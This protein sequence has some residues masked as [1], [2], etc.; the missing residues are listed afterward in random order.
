M[1]LIYFFWMLKIGYFSFY[2]SSDIEGE[3]LNLLVVVG[4][5]LWV[6]LASGYESS[7]RLSEG[8]GVES[9]IVNFMVMRGGG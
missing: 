7:R 3:Y 9:I 5:G 1:Y 2:N 6:F 4:D 8:K